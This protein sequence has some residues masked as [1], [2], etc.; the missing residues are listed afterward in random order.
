[1][2]LLNGSSDLQWCT[3]AALKMGPFLWDS[4]T[5]LKLGPLCVTEP[6]INQGDVV[7]ETCWATVH[8]TRQKHQTLKRSHL[9]LP[10]VSS[11][12]SRNPAIKGK[13]GGAGK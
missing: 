4:S 6:W 11:S 13:G 5:S 8:T 1:M 10:A 3:G 9:W 7:N 12:H 2:Q